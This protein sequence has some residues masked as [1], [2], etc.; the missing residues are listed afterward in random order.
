MNIKRAIKKR[1][2]SIQ[3]LSN[4]SEVPLYNIEKYLSDKKYKLEEWELAAI[5][6]QLIHHF[7]V[8]R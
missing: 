3:E 6:Y 1:N 2:V 5:K 7:K 8:K 4:R